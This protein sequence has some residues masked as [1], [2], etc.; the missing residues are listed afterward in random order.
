LDTDTP[1][2]LL[3][4]HHGSLGIA[5]SL[6]RL[7]V[8][9]YA[10]TADPKVPAGSSRYLRKV[11]PFSITEPH[12]LERLRG[13]ATLA[14]DSRPPLLVPTTDETVLFVEDN[15]EALRAAFVFPHQPEGLPRRISSKQGMYELC[16]AHGIPTPETVFPDGFDHAMELARGIGFPVVLKPVEAPV[17]PLSGGRIFIARYRAE[18]RRAFDRIGSRV[19]LQEYI[20][21]G[22]TTVWVFNGYFG[23]D[24]AC[25]FGMTGRKIRQFPPFG[26]STSLGECAP[27]PEVDALAK[28]LMLAV[29]YRGI[30]DCGFRFDARDRTYKL[31]DVNPRIGS[32]FRLFVDSKG[33]DVARAAY[34]HLTGQPVDT[35]HPVWGRRWVVED[36]DLTSS[37]RLVRHRQLSVLRWPRSYAGVSEAAWFARD[38]L[39]PFVRMPVYRLGQVR[40]S[41][42]RRLRGT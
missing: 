39:A 5:R 31:L 42:A 35:G 12:A 15:A 32:T 10:A 25:L 36:F 34:L 2:L 30:L 23:D 40:Q 19:L 4:L 26:G 16:Q 24:S 8:E 11:V 13:H 17:V 38:D 6:G 27:C 9:V 1:V 14:S 3:E 21:G 18:M 41:S 20:P 29:G 7:G 22:S 33:M 37:A 28:Q